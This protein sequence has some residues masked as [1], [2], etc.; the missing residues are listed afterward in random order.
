MDGY[1]KVL[2][3]VKYTYENEQQ[4]KSNLNSGTEYFSFINNSLVSKV[5]QNVNYNDYA[6]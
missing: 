2:G 1:N 4:R 3:E 5:S 6:K